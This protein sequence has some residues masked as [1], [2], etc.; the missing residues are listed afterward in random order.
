[1][2]TDHLAKFVN[3]PEQLVDDFLVFTT[4]LTSNQVELTK[5]KQWLSRNNLIELNTRM[6]IPEEGRTKVSDQDTYP[7]LHLYYHICVA[8]GIF[9]KVQIKSGKASLKGTDRLSLFLQ[10]NKTEQYMC[11]LE[12]FWIDINWE[13]LQFRESFSP[14]L[15]VSMLFE[16]ILEFPFGK[17]ITVNDSPGMKLAPFLSRWNY[18]MHYFSYFGF[19][20]LT[21]DQ[22]RSN[23]F[24]AKYHYEAKTITPTLLLYQLGSILVETRDVSEWNLRLQRESGDW[25]GYTY[26]PFIMAFIHLFPDGELVSALPRQT[27]IFVDGTYDLTVSLSTKCWRT[28]RISSHHTLHQLHLAIQS[29]FN[30]GNDHLYAY[31]MDGQSWSRFAFYSP[32]DGEEPTAD[33]AKLG[34]LN[35][36]IGQS[37]LYLFDYG[38]EWKFQVR[39]EKLSDM[40]TKDSKPQLLEE[41]GESPEQYGW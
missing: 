14:E 13:D 9:I 32:D 12:T 19:W 5:S 24:H 36:A 11:L 26:E 1:M 41:R 40:N 10:M 17:T 25:L 28:I 18:F 4:Y 31:F 2:Y 23:I 34:E 22:E 30:F 6:S 29:A 20:E 16:Y 27:G 38:S 15:A 21:K 37:F 39:I 8:A 33:E 7:L 35:L 3:V